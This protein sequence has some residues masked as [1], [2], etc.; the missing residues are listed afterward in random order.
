L[1]QLNVVSHLG[2]KNEGIKKTDK[3]EG[4]EEV[5]EICCQKCSPVIN[6]K[7]CWLILSKNCKLI[8]SHLLQKYNTR[9]KKKRLDRK[10]RLYARKSE[11]QFGKSKRP[12]QEV[13]LTAG[14]K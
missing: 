5:Q 8:K 4:H 3:H 9:L 13:E 10:I 12:Q 7:L 14:L 2:A 6:T 1:Q 11:R